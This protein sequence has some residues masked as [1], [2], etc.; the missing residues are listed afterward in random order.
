MLRSKLNGASGFDLGEINVKTKTLIAI[1]LVFVLGACRSGM[2]VS[3]PVEPEI[4][5][6]P[7]AIPEATATMPPPRPTPSV[8]QEVIESWPGMKPGWTTFLASPSITTTLYDPDGYIWARHSQGAYRWEITSGKMENFALEDGFPEG[9]NDW[10]AFDGKIW[11]ALNDGRVVVFDGGHWSEQKL[12]EMPL[13]FFT[14]TADSLWLHSVQE[15]RAFFYE[16]NNWNEFKNIPEKILYPVVLA[17]STKNFL[18]VKGT[19]EGFNKIYRFDGK[20]WSE[21]PNLSGARHILS[22]NHG[23]AYFIFQTMILLS[24]GETYWPIVF[25][26]N[27]FIYQVLG[28]YSLDDNTSIIARVSSPDGEKIFTVY[29]DGST[30]SV[31]EGTYPDLGNEETSDFHMRTWTTAGWL[32]FDGKGIGLYK[33]GEFKKMVIQVEE[34]NLIE[35]FIK[36]SDVI[37]FAPNGNMWLWERN[38]PSYFN[39]NELVQLFPD[40]TMS[41]FFWE[42]RNIKINRAGEVWAISS[43]HFLWR[44]QPGRNPI[45]Y[46]IEGEIEDFDFAPDDSIW[47][48]GKGGFISHV[49]PNQLFYENSGWLNTV[50]PIRINDGNTSPII[51]RFSIG[52]LVNGKVWV[53]FSHVQRFPTEMY[54]YDETT[55]EWTNLGAFYPQHRSMQILKGQGSTLWCSYMSDNRTFLLKHNGKKWEVHSITPKLPRLLVSAPDDAIW[56]LDQNDNSLWHFDGENWKEYTEQLNGIVPDKAFAAPDGAIWF[57]SNDAWIRYQP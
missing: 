3:T 31:A 17:G 11:F 9:V 43:P 42:Y 54:M 14:K 36:S 18:W 27:L 25:P 28:A 20:Q 51:G 10:A 13:S 16:S 47:L 46:E 44:F 23:K 1:L 39:G 48:V 6:Q 41:M 21:Y 7:S 35:S 30:R 34:N 49:D 2:P 55:K 45:Q 52:A 5:F 57:I 32:L 50:Q 24:D 15:K 12:T 8:A 22:A 38:G 56:L 4:A 53:S 33:D 26:D 37:G 19:E 40:E 29:P